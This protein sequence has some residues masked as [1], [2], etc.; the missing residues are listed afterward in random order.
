MSKQVTATRRRAFLK[1]LRETGSLTLSAERAKVGKDWALWNRKR[2][3]GFDAAC[4]EAIAGA[5]AALE[6]ERDARRMAPP[7]GWG[8]LDGVQLVV[9]GAPGRRVQIRRARADGWS[10]A[11][12]DRFLGVLA[13]TCNVKAAC[14]EI[15]MTQASAYYH[16]RQWAAFA[17]R[18]DRAV[19][20][21]YDRLEWAL[22]ENA[23][24]VFSGDDVPPDNPMPPVTATDAINLLRMNSHAVNGMGRRR[25]PRPRAP[26]VEEVWAEIMRRV[27][28]AE[29]G[30]AVPAEVRARDREEWARRGAR[31][32]GWPG[33]K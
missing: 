31:R 23:I 32:A 24:N 11:V 30:K 10:P 20:I 21:G 5:R 2:D 19:S 29:R 9:R 16:R 1:A 25:R 22:I 8:T 17:D 13:A 28:A 14:A 7:K 12:E 4:R 6:A 18:W 33:P 27:D 15:R 3:P 26:D